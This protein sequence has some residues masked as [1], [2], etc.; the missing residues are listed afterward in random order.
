MG[1]KKK[2]KE[3][4]VAQDMTGKMMRT[5]KEALDKV[6]KSDTSG[7]LYDDIFRLLLGKYPRLILPLL[8]E[9][10]GEQFDGDEEMY[11]SRIAIRDSKLEDGVLVVRF[12]D[13][14]VLCLRSSHSTPDYFK[15]CRI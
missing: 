1:R 5:G 2:E 12:P 10:F 4:E 8:S 6:D 11:D 14:A 7:T 13:S 3:V 15:V 9:L